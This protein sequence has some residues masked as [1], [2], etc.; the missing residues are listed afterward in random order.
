MDGTSTEIRGR[1][2]T[3]Q[4]SKKGG[5][6]ATGVE[7]GLRGKGGERG[8]GGGVGGLPAGRLAK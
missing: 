7:G 2:A 8:R 6:P 4:L 1:C 3:W 5:G